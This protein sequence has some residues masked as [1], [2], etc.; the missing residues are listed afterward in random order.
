MSSTINTYNQAFIAPQ[1][2]IENLEGSEV[3]DSGERKF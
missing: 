1:D 2:N 3:G